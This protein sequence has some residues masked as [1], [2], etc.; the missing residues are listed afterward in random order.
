M[1]THPEPV[2]AEMYRKMGGDLAPAL[3]VAGLKAALANLP[4]D[5]LIY[6]YDHQTSWSH[7]PELLAPIISVGSLHEN[8]V[9]LHQG[10]PEDNG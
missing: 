2:T 3:T 9:T 8:Q 5:A 4:D 1:V 6:I 10:P 7:H